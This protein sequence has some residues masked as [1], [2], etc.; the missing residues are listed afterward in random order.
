MSVED[1]KSKQIFLEIISS[2]VNYIPVYGQLKEFGEFLVG[3]DP[4][5]GRE[6]DS[7]ERVLFVNSTA[8]GLLNV[9]KYLSD[10]KSSK[11][12]EV[13]IAGI[14]KVKVDGSNL[15]ELDSKVL[16]ASKNKNSNFGNTKMTNQPNG[17]YQAT[18]KHDPVYG[19]A[20]KNPIPNDEV[21][22]ILLNNGYK[23]DGSKQVYTIYE[24]QIIKFQP[25]A[26]SGTMHPY[27]VKNTSTKEVPKQVYE[28]M[29]KDGLITKPEYTKLINNKWNK[30]K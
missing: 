20:S 21:G 24:G 18:P 1:V 4:I 23:V 28:L 15:D 25:D 3:R 17:T 30:S 12:T 2:G 5:T 22:Q 11:Q 26:T 27:I 14:G 7:L 6:L 9:D 16:E 13:E 19:W 10:M 8:K 29:L